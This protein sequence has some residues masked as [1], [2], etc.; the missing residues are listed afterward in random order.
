[1]P[2]AILI[3]AL[4]LSAATGEPP[5]SAAAA[6]AAVAAPP[7]A[8]PRA[9]VAIVPFENVTRIAGARATVMETM[10]ATLAKKGFDV[11]P[12]E[13]VEGW[14]LAHRVRYLDSLPAGQLGELLFAVGA[15][16]AVVGTV[17][18]W[19]DDEKDPEV[20]IAARLLTPTGAVLWSDVRGLTGA[21][22]AGALGL[23]RAVSVRGVADRLVAALLEAVPPLHLQAVRAAP[24]GLP[25]TLPAPMAFRWREPISRHVPIAILP[26][27]NFGSDRDATRVVEAILQDRLGGQ[28]SL[29]T[30]PTADL[31]LAVAST[32]LRSPVQ[33]SL[34]QLRVLAKELGTSLFV[35]GT[36]LTFGQTTAAGERP[37]RWSST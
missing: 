35:R 32:G 34:D 10:A 21:E 19:R 30:V 26:L 23:S 6:P 8:V 9:R 31:R 16:A 7:A 29:T 14:L 25:M 22:T 18:A 4:L 17:L 28:A 27:Q 13:A 11:V 37:P 5:E 36:I 12:E 2:P 20:A 1:M 3:A 33:L 24:P 15:D